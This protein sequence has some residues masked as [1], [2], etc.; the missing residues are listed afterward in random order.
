MNEYQTN[1]CLITKAGVLCTEQRG[2][3]GDTGDILDALDHIHSL[4]DDKREFVESGAKM[5]QGVVYNPADDVLEDVRT[6]YQGRGLPEQQAALTVHR[7][8]VIYQMVMRP[9]IEQIKRIFETKSD[10]D[11]LYQ[12]AEQAFADMAQFAINVDVGTIHE[13]DA[14]V[15]AATIFAKVRAKRE[16]ERNV[17]PQRKR[18]KKQVE[19]MFVEPQED[20][21][22]LTFEV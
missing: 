3:I 9:A 8:G 11:E 18:R 13:D 20:V 22:E 17:K 10:P 16:A 21:E 19:E 4:L 2:K 15:A 7:Y 6:I 5:Y 14:R 12:S 1:V